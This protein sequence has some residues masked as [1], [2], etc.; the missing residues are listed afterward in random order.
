MYY[1][2]ASGLCLAALV[3]TVIYENRRM[4]KEELKT[5]RILEELSK[6]LR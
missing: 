2:A 5:K 6:G 1:L 4:K 3:G